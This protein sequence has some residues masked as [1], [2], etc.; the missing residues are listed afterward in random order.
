M[1]I[2]LKCKH[3]NEEMIFEVQIL[4]T[5]LNYLRL[6]NDNRKEKDY[7]EFGSAFIYTCKQSCDASDEECVIVQME[8]C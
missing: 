4:P 6:A 5:L 1:D 7:L 8:K 2:P 3:C